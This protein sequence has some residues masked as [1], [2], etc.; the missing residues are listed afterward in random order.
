MGFKAKALCFERQG[1]AASKWV[2]KGRQLVGVEQLTGAW[3][4]RMFG[5][6]P[7]PGLADLSTCPFQYSLVR[8]YSPTSTNSSIRRNR[9]WR[10]FS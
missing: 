3:M 10:S 5:A 1:T 8:G 7:P 9:L 4:F 2:V 6:C